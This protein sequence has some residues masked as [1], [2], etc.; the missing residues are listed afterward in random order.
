MKVVSAQKEKYVKFEDLDDYEFFST[1]EGYIYLK[2]PELL[3]PYTSYRYNAID[4]EENQIEYIKA[5]TDVE[6]LKGEI[7]I[8]N[9]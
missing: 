1:T 4:I 3:N 2:I 5:D 7:V 8:Y 6:I 9:S